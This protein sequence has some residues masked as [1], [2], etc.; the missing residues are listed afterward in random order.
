MKLSFVKGVDRNITRYVGNVPSELAFNNAE[1]DM[2]IQYML[3]NYNNNIEYIIRETSP[4]TRVVI[5]SPLIPDEPGILDLP[6][7]ST[8]LIKP[9]TIM[10]NYLITLIS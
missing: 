10:W 4:Y 6:L 7:K 3:D 9:S 1:L 8:S 5:T 2:F